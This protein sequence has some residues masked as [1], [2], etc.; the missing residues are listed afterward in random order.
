MVDFKKIQK[1]ADIFGDLAGVENMIWDGNPP[2]FNQQ[3]QQSAD[4]GF[5][6][7]RNPQQSIQLS[8]RSRQMISQLEPAFQEKAAQL[9]LQ[10][11]ARGLRPE[12]VESARSQ[13]RQNELYEQGRSQPGQ[14][15]TKTKNSMHTKR[16]AID[17][18]Q[19]DENGEITY[20]PDDPSFW[21]K[22]GQIGRSLGLRWGGDFKSFKDLP[23]FQF[24]SQL[25]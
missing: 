13:D 1:F 10:G 6:Q 9:I 16:L 3:L 23:H 11:L 14:I 5:Q 7:P 25:Q 17:I 21:E 20:E 8:E 19:L 15:V 22:M 24:Q 2:I 4:F 18:A 12:I